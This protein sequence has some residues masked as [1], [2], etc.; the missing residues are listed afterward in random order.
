[1][2]APNLGWAA[3]G[4]GLVSLVSAVGYLA[5]IMGLGERK[6][7]GSMFVLVSFAVG[8]LFGDVFLHLLPETL[9]SVQSE[10]S[11]P[12]LLMGG[13]LGFFALE[14]FIRWRHCHLPQGARHHHPV[15]G[16]TIIGDSVHNA[17][18]GLMIG[19]AFQVDFK[20]GVA[21]TL[22]VV[23]H[24]VP[25]E[26]GDFGIMIHGGLSP[27]R[28]LGF[29]LLSALASFLGLGLS[30]TA[31]AVDPDLARAITAFSAGGF[32]YIAGSDLVPEL[33]HEVRVRRSAIQFAAILAG[34]GSMALVGF[35]FG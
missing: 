21:T 35:F 5:L 22:A 28:A 31:G 8:A 9:G 14:K 17:L 7:R 6:V 10:R 18:D 20:A 11:A 16:L 30:Y 26:L 12:W 23:C 24:E 27:R 33:H 3:A 29:N 13:L 32:L 25:Q 15:V 4:V 2:N 34:I 1:M 19:A